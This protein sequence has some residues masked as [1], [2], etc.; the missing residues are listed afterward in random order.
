M[1]LVAGIA[2]AVAVSISGCTS[3]E[4]DRDWR[5]IDMCGLIDKSQLSQI[6]DE[7]DALTAE[8]TDQDGASVGCKFVA[9]SGTTRLSVG[10]KSEDANLAEVPPYAVVRTFSISDKTAYVSYERGGNCNLSVQLKD[11]AL[12]M[13]ISPGPEKKGIEPDDT[14]DVSCKA[15]TPLIEETIE[16]VGLP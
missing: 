4:G 13:S 9:P 3:D 5:T 11:L 1:S 10:L 14:S 8:R 7:P 6:A 12:V 15:Q 2:A 16:R